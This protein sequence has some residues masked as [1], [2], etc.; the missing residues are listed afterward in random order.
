MANETPPPFMANA[1]LN[2]HFDF[3]HPSFLKKDY[4]DLRTDCSLDMDYGDDRAN[5]DDFYYGRLN[6]SGPKGSYGALLIRTLAFG[7]SGGNLIMIMSMAIFTLDIVVS[8]DYCCYHCDDVRY[9][10]GPSMVRLSVSQ[11]AICLIPA[12]SH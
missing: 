4:D 12:S 9:P 8:Y 3:L 5:I 6:I 11:E 2:F 1:I 7:L 10:M